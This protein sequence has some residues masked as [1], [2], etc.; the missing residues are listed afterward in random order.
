[1][2][3]LNLTYG[4]VPL[5]DGSGK[6][7]YGIKTK[8]DVIRSAYLAGDTI[9]LRKQ[10]S[11]TVDFGDVDTLIKTTQ[12]IYT[13]LISM[14]A[15]DIAYYAGTQ[16]ESLLHQNILHFGNGDMFSCYTETG[17]PFTYYGP[18]VEDY[19]KNQADTV[20]GDTILFDGTSSDG[21]TL[22][23]GTN[24]GAFNTGQA[25]YGDDRIYLRGTSVSNGVSYGYM[26]SGE[27]NLAD[28]QKVSIQANARRYNATYQD[29]NVAM[30]YIS[31][32]TAY[33]QTEIAHFALPM[34]GVNSKTEID[35]TPYTSRSNGY[36]TILA[37]G[38]LVEQLGVTYNASG[39]INVYAV[40]LEE[41]DS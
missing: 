37:T 14:E 26:Q 24:M 31:R 30:V 3:V 8:V 21:W 11:N 28:Y 32:T 40:T 29:A 10:V 13:Q 38:A 22:Q 27:I 16:D 41:V 23:T 34:N 17:Y 15:A 6:S 25:Y 36:I 4:V 7:G 1:M 2:A 39:D 19:E 18:S 33:V 9:I 5:D 20:P 12:D 35:L